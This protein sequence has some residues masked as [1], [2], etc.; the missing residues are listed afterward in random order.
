M[1][2]DDGVVLDRVRFAYPADRPDA[3]PWMRYGDLCRFLAAHPPRWDEERARGWAQRLEVPLDRPFR[4][5]S[6]GEV[7]KAMLAATLAP[8]PDVR[9]GS[10]PASR[11]S[12]APRS[13]RR[14]R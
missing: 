6:R 13:A 11:C 10:T 5:M 3:W 14:A 8:D 2:A 12:K 1:S 9:A 4:A 7:M